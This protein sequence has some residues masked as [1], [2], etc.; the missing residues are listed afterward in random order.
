MLLLLLL[1]LLLMMMIII[2]III[3]ITTIMQMSYRAPNAT[4]AAQALYRKSHQ[5]KNQ[6]KSMSLKI[7]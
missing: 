4:V 5:V 2:I 6:I 1:L 7:G 3:I